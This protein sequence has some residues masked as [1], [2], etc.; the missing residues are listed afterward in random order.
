V[1]ATVAVA[2]AVLLAVATPALAHRVDEYLQ[3]TTISVEKSRVQAQIRLTPGVQVFPVVRRFIDADRD[4]TISLAE[5]RAYA[6]RVLRDLV[7]EVDGHRLSLRLVSSAFASV[8]EMEEGRG[9]IRIDFESAVPDG[10]HDRRLVFEN[11]HLAQMSVYLVNG[12]VPPDPDVEVTGQER[13]YEQSVYQM[14][15]VQA[16]ASVAEPPSRY[17]LGV[18]MLG[19][20]ALLLLATPVALLSRRT[21]S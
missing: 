3:A 17:P 4:G 1:K 15:Y 19:I 7:L 16:N 6:D 21:L 11:H 18:A 20:G 13:N 5:Q 12:V 10:G 14:T 9:T 8:Q 2:G